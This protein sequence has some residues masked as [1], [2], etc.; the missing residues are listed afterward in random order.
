M[1]AHEHV[2]GIPR[3]EEQPSLAFAIRRLIAYRPLSFLMRSTLEL[4]RRVDPLV[5]MLLA[6]A[7]YDALQGR[8]V[9]GLSLAGIVVLTAAFG[10]AGIGISLLR[11]RAGVSLGFRV[12]GLLQ[13]KL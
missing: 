8:P 11:S 12:S 1:S 5:H 2:E 3:R 10:L 7:F 6:R 9:A 13:R 4:L